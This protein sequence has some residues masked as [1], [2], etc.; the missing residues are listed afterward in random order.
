MGIITPSLGIDNSKSK[1]SQPLTMADALFTRTQQSVLGLLFGQPGHSFYTNEIIKKSGGGSGAVQREL[2]RLMRS[3]L[4]TVERIGSQKHYQANRDAPLFQELCS[5]VNKTVALVEP[6]KAVL[7]PFL[8]DIEMAFVC[9]SVA[10]GEDT[11]SSD[12]DLM[13][14]SDS[15][16]YAN[17]FPALEG[18]SVELHR[19]VEPTLYSR[20]ELAKRIKA[21]NSFVRRVLAQPK[22]WIIG[23][24]C[25]LPTG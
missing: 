18:A 4:I 8:P 13:I 25:E 7:H 14:V 6:L 2:S 24:E 11:A 5:V 1:Q 10:K 16:T 9:G 15:L 21:D 19:K 20:G 12:I 17:V 22:I 3:G 23:R